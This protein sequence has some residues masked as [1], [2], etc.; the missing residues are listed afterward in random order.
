[1]FS[2]ITIIIQCSLYI[3]ISRNTLT[4]RIINQIFRTIIRI[5]DINGIITGQIIIISHLIIIWI[6]FT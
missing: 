3:H 4:T 1:M 2:E 6:Q 5:N